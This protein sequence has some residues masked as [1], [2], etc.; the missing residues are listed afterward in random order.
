MT[1]MLLG[2]VLCWA[3]L[4]PAGAH[5]EFTSAALLSGTEQLQFD[6][7]DAPALAADGDYAAFEGSLAGV[8]GIYRRDLQT[9]AIEL[10]AGGD[11][12]AP[13]EPCNVEQQPLDACDAAA[14]SISADGRYIAFTTTADLQPQ[15][16]GSSEG[17]P[18]VDRGCPEVYV[19]DMGPPGQPLPADAPGAYSLASALDGTR[20][21]IT[22]AAC[23][24]PPNRGGFA[25]AGAQAAPA[26]AISADG[27]KVAF[28][29]LSPSN[30]MRGPGC[31]PQAGEPKTP[32]SE[33]PP[34]VA[35]SQVAVRDLE[36]HTTTLVTVTPSGEAIPGGGAYPSQETE[37]RTIGTT[38]PF[39]EEPTD[40]TAALSADGST[41]AWLGTNVPLQVPSAAEIGELGYHAVGESPLSN[42]AEP[43]WRRIEDG[44]AA[45]TERLL[46]NA[47][48]NLFYAYGQAGPNG[49]E[50]VD[51]S[52]SGVE[53]ALFIAPALSA[54]GRTVALIA[55]APRPA[56][57]ESFKPFSSETWPN[58]DAYVI[59]VGEGAA[60]APRVT[61]L[62]ATP[63]Y[64][65]D[66][67]AVGDIDNI[68]ISPDGTRVA[69][70]TARTQFEST[71]LALIGP[72]LAYNH[73]RELY[74]VDLPR[75][76][77]QRVSFAYEGG[78][79]RGSNDRGDAGD[80]GLLSFSGDGQ[81]LA[82]ASTATN[83]FYGDGLP[84]S[85][86]YL[87]HEITA[88][89]APAPQEIGPQA[90]I[91]TP[92]PAWVLSATAS[93]EPDGS[94]LIDAEVPG[95]GRLTADAGA[96]LPVSAGSKVARPVTP[97]VKKGRGRAARARAHGRRTKTRSGSGK[98]T[99]VPTRAVARA[100]TA[101]TGA[102][103][104]QLRVRVL[105]RY[106]TLV[107]GKHG[108][109]AVL[110]ITFL[111]PGQRTLTQDIPVTFHLTERKKAKR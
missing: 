55:D 62:T 80:T 86:V 34:E 52:F 61:A 26:A 108:L 36:T 17:E 40:S 82:F 7:A 68:A 101:V 13:E 45:V 84:E 25:M 88:S 2:V 83:L 30:L 104:V 109:Y 21:G 6:Y 67:A 44:P 72:P 48:L 39:G 8:P 27:T 106:S 71:S 35:P 65:A 110:Q 46:A 5:A 85:E 24:S 78:R 92:A 76:T 100:D 93:P 59:Q 81:S 75:A 9:G 96:Q 70:D 50:V 20:A 73:V 111:A 51:G 105:N 14:P 103:E 11:A 53:G 98:S 54:N 77:L 16:A 10:V 89:A 87:T 28:T 60:G 38:E 79:L 43:L 31:E 32:L 94:V 107:A 12:A 90:S 64:A 23:P 33:C 3:S 91:P 19:R 69:F 47:G 22:F 41:V 1:L 97:A 99:A 15:H 57:E 95:A 29:V 42:E 74:E 56:A 102:G 4:R 18:A 58:S 49:S 63:N 37:P 66:Q